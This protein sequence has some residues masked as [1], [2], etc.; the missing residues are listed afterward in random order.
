MFCVTLRSMRWTVGLPGWVWVI[1]ILFAYIVIKSPPDGN[2]VLDLIPRL[3]SGV[4]NGLIKI[5]NTYT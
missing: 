5:I 1:L 4:G 3:I 2:W